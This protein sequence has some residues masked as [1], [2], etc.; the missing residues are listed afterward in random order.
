M[1]KKE[2]KTNSYGYNVGWGGKGVLNHTHGFYCYLWV[3][4]IIPGSIFFQ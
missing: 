1:S 4:K 2:I 3:H